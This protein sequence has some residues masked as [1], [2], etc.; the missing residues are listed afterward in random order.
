MIAALDTQKPRNIDNLAFYI[1]VAFPTL[2]YSVFNQ[3]LVSR[4]YHASLL[5]DLILAFLQ[6]VTNS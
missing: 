3:S 5:K 1:S 4:F 2:V 6:I